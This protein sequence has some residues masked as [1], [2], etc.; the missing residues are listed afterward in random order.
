MGD[1]QRVAATLI[2]SL[3]RRLAPHLTGTYQELN[4]YQRR[5]RAVEGG[6][7]GGLMKQTFIEKSSEPWAEGKKGPAV[8]CHVWGP[9]RH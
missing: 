2:K 5:K 7:S 9:P 3:D 1:T 6:P 8:G 4:L